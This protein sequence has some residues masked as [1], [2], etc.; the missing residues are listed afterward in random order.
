MAAPGMKWQLL[1]L[2]DENGRSYD[3]TAA[4]LAK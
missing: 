4:L 1:E 2:L 3:E